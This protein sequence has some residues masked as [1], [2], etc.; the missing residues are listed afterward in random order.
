MNKKI[1]D[2]IRT[3]LITMN[4]GR[5]SM[6]GL[7]VLMFLF[8]GGTG[9]LISPIAGLYVPFLMGGFFVPM[10]F[11]NEIKYHSEKMHALLP[12]SRRDLVRS[13]FLLSVGLYVI[14]CVIFYLLML[15]SLKLKLWY[16]YMGEDAEHIDLIKL[17]A[18]RSGGGF[19][20]IGLFNL[21]Y[22][23]V[24]SFGLM[25]MSSSLRRYFRDNRSFEAS[26]TVG[27]TRK[28]PQKVN[29]TFLPILVPVILLVLISSGVLPIGA[30]GAVLI[31]LTV[32]LA[33]AADGFLLSAVLITIA[34]FSAIYKY[35]CTVLEYDEKEL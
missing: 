11:N 4:G 23:A 13:R 28:A 7:A 31:Q 9:F 30:A 25:I 3:D 18:Q 26:L 15:L 16:L 21:L 6:R 24:L 34:V 5:N 8:C 17:L 2:L 27:K 1:L 29:L 12:V 32:Q 19:T 35:I 22:F 33:G 14:V 10:L 20:E